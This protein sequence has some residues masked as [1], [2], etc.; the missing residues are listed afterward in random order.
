MTKNSVLPL[1][2]LLFCALAAPAEAAAKKNSRVSLGIHAQASPTDGDAFVFPITYGN[3]PQ[4]LKLQKMPLITERDIVAF[5]PFPAADGTYGAYFQLGQHGSKVI[6]QFTMAHKGEVV[7]CTSNGRY[8]ISLM[9][10]NPIHDGIITIP[11]GFSPVEIKAMETS[12]DLIGQ[13]ASSKKI[14]QEMLKKAM[15]GEL[16]MS[17]EAERLKEASKRE[18]EEKRKI[19]AERKRQQ[20]EARRAQEEQKRKQKETGKQGRATATS[21]PAPAAPNA[22]P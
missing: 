3:P 22:M 8:V 7:V 18:R 9:I 12:F 6:Q 14:R 5:Y 15:R 11:Q 4:Q 16:D 21:T 10:T 2:L 20:Q 17:E 1:A 13:P 19:E